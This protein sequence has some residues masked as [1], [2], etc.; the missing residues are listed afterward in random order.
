[1]KIL[2]IID[3]LNQGGAERQIIGLT[4]LLSDKR[5]DSKLISYGLDTFYLPLIKEQKI[6]FVQLV[7]KEHRYSKLIELV[8]YIKREK[9]DVVIS[10]KDGPNMMN[11]L[12]KAAGFKYKSIVSERNT[13]QNCDRRT[14][15]KFWLYR[16]SDFIVPNSFSQT[17]FISLNYSKYVRKL[18]TITNFVNTDKYYPSNNKVKNEKTKVLIAAKISPQKNILNFIKAIDK[19]RS[20][21]QNFEVVWYGNIVKGNESY[22]EE[23]KSL[24]SRLKLNDYVK[25]FS[26]TNDLVHEYQSAD[27][28][29]LPSI[30]EGYPNVVCEAM[31]SGLP[32]L[33]GNVCD[34]NRIIEDNR[35]GYLF[36]PHKSDDIADTLL[37]Y[38]KLPNEEKCRMGEKSRE[39]A[40]AKF[41]EETFVNN[42]IEIIK[43]L[44]RTD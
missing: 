39:L 33:C 38:I 1:M 17:E 27:V 18:K 37:R 5:F 25:F 32:I 36:N 7:H 23:C 40:L 43:D 3:G 44:C 22:N 2:C 24:I 21:T 30:Y 41:S 34:N 10:Y 42:Y 29:C 12:L 4:K 31:S 26:A 14:K 8:K 11:C 15:T 35:N 16:F 28:F 20:W 19:L 13:T 6:N 9:P